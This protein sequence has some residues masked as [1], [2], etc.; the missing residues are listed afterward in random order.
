MKERFW[1]TCTSGSKC[2]K[3]L[4]FIYFNENYNF[5]NCIIS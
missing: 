1:L 3:S 2:M 4:T 5:Q